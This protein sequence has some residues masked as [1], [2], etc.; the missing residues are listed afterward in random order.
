MRTAQR[1]RRVLA[2][3]AWV[4]LG[5]G[6][7]AVALVGRVQPEFASSMLVLALA[8]FFLTLLAWLGVTA[9]TQPERRGQL[10]ALTVS[11]SLWAIGSAMLNAD[12]SSNPRSFPAPGEWLFLASYIGM[13]A[14]VIS[15]TVHR[16]TRSLSTWLEAIVVCGGTACLAG[17]L[18]N[19]HASADAGT[20]ALPLL[21]ML[22]YP[23]ADLCLTLLVIAQLALRARGPLRSS[24]EL[25]L[26]FGLLT[27]AD[28]EFVLHLPGYVYAASSV[29]SDACYGVAFALVV[30]HACRPGDA[31]EVFRP[32]PR[33]Q[34]PILMF[35][36]GGAALVDL[37]LPSSDAVMPYL[38]VPG[39]VTML[40]AGGRLAVALRDAN[41]A[42]EAFE[43]ALS[44]DLTRLPNRRAML[45]ELEERLAGPSEFGLMIMDLDGF[46]DVNDTLGHAAGDAV[47]R[48]VA[49]RLR[50]ALPADVLLAR[51]GGDE[52][53]TLVPGGDEVGL[54][55]TGQA[56]LR[57]VGQ[58][59]HI[60]GVDLVT[61]ASVGMTLRSST[62][63]SSTELLHRAD[64]AMYH[65][66]SNRSGALLYDADDDHFSR[67]K[68]QLAEDLRKGI[69]SSQLTLWY[70]PQID[71]AT[72]RI[73][74]L[75]A[76][77][78]WK[79]PVDGVLAP[80]AFLPAA[81]RAGLMLAVSN[82]VAR[83]VVADLRRWRSDGLEIRVAINCA[84]PELMSGI[85]LPRLYEALR[86]AGV[87]PE[88]LVI[89]LTEDSFLNDPER[90]RSV[91]LDIREHRLQISIDDYG[92]G[93]SS[94]AYLRDLPVQELKIDRSFIAVMRHDVRSRMI[95]SS[96][97]QLAKALGLRTVA[98]GV[99]DAATAA[100]L[101]AMGVDVLQGFHLVRPLPPEQV[102]RWL[103]DWS[104]FTDLGDAFPSV[105]DN[106]S[107]D[108]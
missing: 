40:A 39:I 1:T 37:A 29:V 38:L 73:C 44:D 27:Y 4:V 17:V 19:T 20:E 51:L 50:A 54:L 32:P 68:L 105:E 25:L 14:F 75:E 79:H 102:Q 97:L 80:M 13:V 84:P 15:D 104:A 18:L 64:I 12:S 3:A 76:L 6:L 67:E 46:K 66:K 58:P 103:R 34:R 78:R 8:L 86:T 63:S 26:G 41:R 5:L 16:L 59:Q 60:E 43:L 36:A 62:D 31:V 90:A 21:L 69:A 81:R 92:S 45:A 9:W 23:L 11:V 98:E 70:Q 100:D 94:L 28:S 77:V 57:A 93:F 24:L 82:E 61:H 89:E 33:R 55:E 108:R 95:V 65:A 35:T 88:N 2:V 42:A 30:S 101:V 87:P 106:G 99:E 96:T 91:L 72:Q 71:A 7:G 107:L 52:F 83:I 47:L 85:F 74:G 10:C 53:A 22:L 56:I 48:S 49:A